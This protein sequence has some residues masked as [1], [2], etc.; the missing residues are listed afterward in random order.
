M[1][2]VKNWYNWKIISGENFNIL[3]TIVLFV[4][5]H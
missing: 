5:K 2:I 4:E 3:L 1:G